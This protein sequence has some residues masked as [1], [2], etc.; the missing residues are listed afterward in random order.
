[1]TTLQQAI[2]T[3][4]GTERS[5]NC[6][7][8]PDRNASAS[9]NVI[10]GLWVCY[11]CGAK[12]KVDGPIDI[13]PHVLLQN[14]T[15]LLEAEEI[16]PYPEAWLAL[17]TGPSEYWEQRFT[18]ATI[19]HFQLG[20]DPVKEMACY[21]LRSASGAIHG[22]VHRNSDFT[23][24]RK[25]RYPYGVDIT[26][27]LF[28][29]HPAHREVVVL[30]E[31][32][33]DAMALWEVGIEAFGIYGTRPSREQLEL[34]FKVDPKRVVLAFDQDSS[35]RRATAEVIDMAHRWVDIAVAEWPEDDG[36]DPAELTSEQRQL[37]IG[38][39]AAN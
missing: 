7:V 10:K 22:L 19:T 16:T 5:F 27:Y 4:K 21:P 26:N 8:H 35:G 20:F 25:Y 28:N 31:G 1:M 30:V 32:A 14:V 34:I 39:L 37:Y 17:Y 23:S 9:V 2:S 6:H 15:E 11:A 33:A 18:A 13:D 29:Y 3:G 38:P 24:K 36:K 12:G